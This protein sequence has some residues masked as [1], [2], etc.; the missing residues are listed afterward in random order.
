VRGIT[1]TAESQSELRGASMRII[2][3]IAHPLS[4]PRSL[5]LSH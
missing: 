3:L 1:F 2:H 4:M 5:L